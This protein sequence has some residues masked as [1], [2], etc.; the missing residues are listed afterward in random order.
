MNDARAGTNPKAGPAEGASGAAASGRSFDLQS[1]MRSWLG[2][3][4]VIFALII[5]FS[6]LQPRFMS[7]LN[8]QNIVIQGSALLVASLA[9]TFPI[10]MGS[11]DLSVGSVASL[12]G[13]SLAVFLEARTG[14]VHDLAIPLVLLIGLA[15]GLLNGILFAVMRVPSFLATLGTFFM[16]DGLA[17]FIISGIPIPI[18]MQE[19]VVP[20]FDSQI[21]PV[22]TMSIWAMA[23]LVLS[24]LGCR[25]TRL[26]RNFYAIGGS[27][28]AALIAGINVRFVKLTAFALSGLLA[29]F[30]GVL[31]SIHSLSGSSGQNAD[32]LLP[33]I[34]AIVIGGTALSG[35]AGGPH[36]TLLGVL[37]LTIL[38]NGMQ[39][40][41][42]D[43]Y[44]QLIV[45]GCVVIAAVILSR[46]KL[47]VF[48]AVK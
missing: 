38:I 15:C 13:V 7:V 11:I 34:G 4:L 24:V 2:T 31:T 45:E 1:A 36:R 21:G 37:L 6:L 14:P 48:A 23:I 28:P 20:I 33:S 40:L 27:E 44:L 17:A 35:G 46:P 30:A 41:A 32:M 22:P 19:P 43:P 42:I 16:L 18:V 10:L 8:W 26:G 39:L 3:L 29:A 25:Y 47:S 9:G 12:V 5:G